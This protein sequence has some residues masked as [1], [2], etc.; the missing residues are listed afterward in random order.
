MVDALAYAQL[1]NNIVDTSSNQYMD[2]ST[3][4]Q[5]LG[6][7]TLTS[8]MDEELLQTTLKRACCR[9]ITNDDGTLDVNVRIPM[10]TPTPTEITDNPD[11]PNY[12]QMNQYRFYDKK[13]SVPTEMCSLVNVDPSVAQSNPTAN[14]TVCDSFY[15]TYCENIKKE[16]KDI[17]GITGD[18]S[19]TDYSIFDTWTGNECACYADLPQWAKDLQAANQLGVFAPTCSF[20]NCK[21]GTPSYIDETSRATDCTQVFCVSNTDYGGLNMGADAYAELNTLTEQNCGVGLSEQNVTGLEPPDAPIVAGTT[22][23][24]RLTNGTTVDDT[25]VTDT[26]TG[27]TVSAIV[28]D[29]GVVYAT[30]DDKSSILYILGGGGGLLVSL[31]SC[32]CLM[33]II[34]ILF[35]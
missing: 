19:D 1:Q 34:F 14:A 31:L 32:C 27:G 33:M 25:T 35:M 22:E 11:W 10:P 28:T 9:G 7:P 16:F 29:E 8:R 26:T 12:S 15:K 21:P 24:D 6:P 20:S 18:F 30:A 2:M 13:I 23:E 3:Y 4:F 17:K 5:G